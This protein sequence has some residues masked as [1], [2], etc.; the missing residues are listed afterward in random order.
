M[1]LMLYKISNGSIEISG[2]T[3]LEE[4]NFEVHDKEK[5]GLVGRN[6]CGKTTLFKGII[7]EVELDQGLGE[8]VFRIDKVGNPNIG[9]VSQNISY[10]VNMKMIDYILL[11]YRDILDVEKEL[12]RLEIEICNNYNESVLDKYNALI[13]QYKYVGGYNYK[14]EYDLALR[15]FGFNDSDKE[16]MLSEFSGGQLTK[17]AFIRLLLSKPDLLLLDEPT[18]HLDIDTTIW[19]ENYL[20]NYS[21][22]VVLVSHDRMFLDN[23]C[24]VVYEIE[25]GCLKRYTG[26]YSDYLRQKKENYEKTLKDYEWQKKEIDRLNRIVQRF[27]YKPS[28]ASMAMSK[29]KQIERMVKIDKPNKEDTKTFRGLFELEFE[30][31]RDVLKVKNLGIGYDKILSYVNLNVERGN[32]VGIIGENGIGK[33]TFLKTLVGK[34]LPLS[35]KFSFGNK[36]EI[37]YF[38][39]GMSDLGVDNTVYNELNFEFPDMSPRDIRNVLGAF[40]FRGD[41]VFKN[42]TDLSGGEKVRL[43]LCKILVHK[44]NLLILDEPTNHLDIMS[45]D[46]IQKMLVSYKGTVLMVSHD[47]YLINQVC[48]SFLVFRKDG[49]KYYPYG[50]SDELFRNVDTFKEEVSCCDK[51][52][53]KVKYVSP[54]REKRKLERKLEKLEDEI[55]VIEEKINLCNKDLL[56]EDVYLNIEKARKIQNE[57]DVLDSKLSEKTK[58]WEEILIL[59]EG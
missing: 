41:D 29:L 38:D 19:L 45:K 16:K 35:G 49:V 43:S 40:E 3:I 42:I 46:V 11:A 7:G 57:I 54:L 18:N 8:D 14:K 23:V 58:E 12:E 51:N 17:L 6:G 56:K 9:Y 30:S 37:G 22:S 39:Q 32:K 2:N 44:P 31:Y 33:S 21:K 13:D 4:I 59:L 28:K 15:K 5:I 10:D 53:K 20:K 1:I 52:L 34:I 24:N 48:N 55:T 36:V 50:Y 26:N 47:R 25:Y 27:K